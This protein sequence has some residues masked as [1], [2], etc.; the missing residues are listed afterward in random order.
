[1]RLIAGDELPCSDPV[2]LSREPIGPGLAVCVCSLRLHASPPVFIINDHHL[3]LRQPDS[4]W[5]QLIWAHLG[6]KYYNN[7]RVIG[8]IGCSANHE[9]LHRV[10][11]FSPWSADAV[12]SSFH[13][14]HFHHIRS[15]ILSGNN[16]EVKSLQVFSK[17]FQVDS[18]LLKYCR[19]NRYTIS[20]PS[21]AASLWI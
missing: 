20:P 3:L 15:S 5:A 11:S 4:S 19:N 12:E 17:N 14:Y 18:S 21:W 7:Y 13:Y 16:Q 9:P 1:M 10:S 2:P 6:S 8:S